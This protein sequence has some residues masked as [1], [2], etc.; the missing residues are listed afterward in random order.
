[1]LIVVSEASYH[2][3]YDH[4][5][6]NYLTQAGVRNTMI[7]LGDVGIHGNGHMMMLEKNSDDIAARD[8]RVAAED[9]AGEGSAKPQRLQTRRHPED[10]LTA[11]STDGAA[12]LEIHRTPWQVRHD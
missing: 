4:C 3:S 11:V 6:A 8:A 2:A 10:A 1:M 5:T 9:G 7:R 12:V